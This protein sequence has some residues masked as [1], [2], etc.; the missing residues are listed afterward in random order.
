MQGTEYYIKECLLK[1]FDI[2][3]QLLN[4]HLKDLSIEECLWQPTEKGFFLIK[5]DDN[6]YKGSFPVSESYNIGAPN[7]AW[8]TWHIDYWWSMVINHTFGNATLDADMIEWNPSIPD[9]QRKF[10][11]LKN[12]WV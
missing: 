8:L 11:E 3:W 12:N 9:I 2:S 6:N 10:Y 4:Y 5:V 7:I 1:Q